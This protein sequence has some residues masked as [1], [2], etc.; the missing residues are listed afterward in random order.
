MFI[1]IKIIYYHEYLSAPETSLV[2][3]YLAEDINQSHFCLKYIIGRY[4]HNKWQARGIF[5]S[6]YLKYGANS[7][8]VQR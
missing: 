7:V 5:R 3:E 8:T 2:L 4:K 1:I 6:T